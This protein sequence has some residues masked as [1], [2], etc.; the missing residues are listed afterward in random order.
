M[1]YLMK[2]SR[3]QIITLKDLKNTNDNNGISLLSILKSYVSLMVMVPYA[4]M[5]DKMFIQL[6]EFV[7]VLTEEARFSFIMEV[8]QNSYTESIVVLG[9]VLYKDAH[10]EAWMKEIYGQSENNNKQPKKSMFFSTEFLDIV[11]KTLFNIKSPVYESFNT[12]LTFI[13]SEDKKSSSHKEKP[14]SYLDT[15]DGFWKKFEILFQSLNLYS[16][17]FLRDNKEKV[18]KNKIE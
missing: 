15:Y 14:E 1:E 17:L 11:K 7:S 9:I 8:I 3:N 10:H 2:I 5:R 6:K 12:D 18:K 16:Y 4:I 13:H